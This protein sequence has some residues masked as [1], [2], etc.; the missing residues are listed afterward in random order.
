[1]RKPRKILFKHFAAHF[2]ELNNY[3]RLFTGSSDSKNTP[4]KRIQRDSPT[5][6]PKLM[7][8]TGLSTRLGFL[9]EE[10]QGYMQNFQDNGSR[11]KFYECGTT[12]KNTIKADANRAS[13]GRKIK[14]GESALPTNP[15][16]GRTGKR[17]ARN[18]GHPINRPT[19]VKTCLLHGPGHST[20]ECKVLK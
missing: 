16:K 13:H 20:E 10:L 1:M 9:N 4:P 12:S 15:E 19:G 3:L 6:R 18:A 8:K 17:K 14:G 2:M 5:R 11:G 7:G